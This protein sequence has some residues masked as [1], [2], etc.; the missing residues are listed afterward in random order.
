[1]TDAAPLAIL[2]AFCV[3][4][5]MQRAAIR[6]W[7][8]REGEGTDMFPDPIVLFRGCMSGVMTEHW[9]FEGPGI[10]HAQV[11]RDRSECFARSVTAIGGDLVGTPPDSHALA[12]ENPDDPLERVLPPLQ[13]VTE[14]GILCAGDLTPELC[15]IDRQRFQQ[16]PGILGFEV[17]PHSHSCS[18]PFL[19]QIRANAE[20]DMCHSEERGTA[21]KRR[22]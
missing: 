19:I 6:C 11:K 21:M 7:M 5:L 13:G 20:Q 8:S 10:P 18:H 15:Q 12:L 2:T 17:E 4:R 14:I 22:A 1:V 9:V 3:A 16:G